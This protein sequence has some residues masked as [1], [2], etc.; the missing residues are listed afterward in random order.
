MA[1][2]R[3]LVIKKICKLVSEGM[4]QKDAAIL[5]GISE[6]TFYEWIKEE[7]GD[8]EADIRSFRS[9]VEASL[10]EYKQKIVQIVSVASVKD[11]KL[12]LAILERRFSEDWGKTNKLEILDPHKQVAEIMDRIMGKK[13]DDNTESVPGRGQGLLPQPSK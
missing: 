3:E 12:A 5:S 8:A 10:I 9:R 4:T 13:K 7:V 6:T 11:G 1:K 2:D